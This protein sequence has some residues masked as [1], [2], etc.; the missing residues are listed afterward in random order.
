MLYN[1]DQEAGIASRNED[2]AVPLALSDLK[3]YPEY[4]GTFWNHLG[5]CEI[6]NTVGSVLASKVHMKAWQTLHLW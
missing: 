1:Q 3:Y 6:E 5:V 2:S 4:S